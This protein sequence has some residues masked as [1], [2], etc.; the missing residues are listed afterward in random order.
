MVSLCHS[1]CLMGVFF[2]FESR[3]Y[4]PYYE[5]C[6]IMY[7]CD[8]ICLEYCTW[9][10]KTPLR[11]IHRGHRP[12][13][14]MNCFRYGSRSKYLYYSYHLRGYNTRN[15]KTIWT[16]ILPMKFVISHKLRFSW[17]FLWL[18]LGKKRN[19]VLSKA[20]W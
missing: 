11:T 5:V 14:Q 12:P 20:R 1:W 6:N 3:L 10:V 4:L 19:M 9:K 13:W 16:T 7:A 8:V 2:R 18:S 15:N 17:I